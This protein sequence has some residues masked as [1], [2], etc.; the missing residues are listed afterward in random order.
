MSFFV[1]RIDTPE[2]PAGGQV[3]GEV[4]F[5]VPDSKLEKARKVTLVCRARV[6][7]SGNGEE[8]HGGAV[9]IH[10]GPIPV[11]SRFPFAGPVPAQG[12]CSFDGRYVKISWEILVEL[13]VPF[14][15]DPKAVG[16]FKVVPRVVDA[17]PNAQ[18]SGWVSG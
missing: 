13:D 11:G 5:D 17:P 16:H 2:V 4:S 14:A 18:A 15:F 10:Q 12:P 9:V 3:S 7:G 1:V 6:H 8:I